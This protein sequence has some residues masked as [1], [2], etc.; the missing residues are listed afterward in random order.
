[1]CSFP[2]VKNRE[3]IRFHM[4]RLGMEWKMLR[5]YHS[6]TRSLGLK[7][8]Q[9][10][11]LVWEWKVTEHREFPEAFIGLMQG[12]LQVWLDQRSGSSS[13]RFS[14]LLSPQAL[15]L[16]PVLLPWSQGGHQLQPEDVASSIS[17][18]DKGWLVFTFQ[19]P[20]LGYS[21]SYPQLRP[22]FPVLCTYQSS[23]YR[24]K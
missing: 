16:S 2:W 10:W 14:Q 12:K 22:S 4:S 1:M 8:S 19:W 11:L 20:K 18:G 17:S 13:L 15:A 5:L 24:Q 6:R 3:Y 21:C 9:A 7:V 23:H